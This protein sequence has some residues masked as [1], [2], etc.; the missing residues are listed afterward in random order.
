MTYAMVIHIRK[1][2]IFSLFRTD[3]CVKATSL[4]KPSMVAA[5]SV[6]RVTLALSKVTIRVVRQANI[7]TFVKEGYK[8][9]KAEKSKALSLT[10][11]Q[12]KPIESMDCSSY[13]NELS[14]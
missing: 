7:S 10:H 13:C 5:L 4:S 12:P 6:K 3:N 14:V 2:G 11:I 9:A 8:I 1:L